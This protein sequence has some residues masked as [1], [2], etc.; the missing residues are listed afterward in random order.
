M[1]K[2]MINIVGRKSIKMYL[3]LVFENALRPFPPKRSTTRLCPTTSFAESFLGGRFDVDLTT[4]CLKRGIE[5]NRHSHG[6]HSSS[7][8]EFG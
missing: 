2:K 7:I 3:C 8:K 1:R 5:Y 6:S 4:D